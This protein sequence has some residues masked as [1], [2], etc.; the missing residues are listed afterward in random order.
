MRDERVSNIIFTGLFIAVVFV[1]TYFVQIPTPGVMGGLIH[2]G[3]IAMFSIALK[4][5][6]K[7]GAISGGVGMAMFDLFSAWYLWA[8]GTLVVRF[9]MGGVIGYVGMNHWFGKNV[10]VNRIIAILLGGVVM[11]V[12]YFVYEALILGVGFAALAGVPGNLVQIAIG[13]I[14]LAIVPFLPD[15]DESY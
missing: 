5:G 4:Y 1:S 2:L 12:L 11:L 7:Y 14:A 15:M 10:L 6:P 9:L 13:F 8:P 3:N